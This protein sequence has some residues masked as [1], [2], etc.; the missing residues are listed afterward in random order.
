MARLAESKL[1]GA[2]AGGPLLRDASGLRTV[3]HYNFGSALDKVD[4]MGFG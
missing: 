2:K 1:V 3:S 4:N